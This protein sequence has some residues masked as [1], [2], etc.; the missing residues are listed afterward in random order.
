MQA[1]QIKSKVVKFVFLYNQK[2]ISH[3]SF[4]FTEISYLVI[5]F[6]VPFRSP[7]S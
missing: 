2:V 4:D 7:L 1:N 6:P 3:G 5:K